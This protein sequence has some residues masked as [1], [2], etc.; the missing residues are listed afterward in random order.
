MQLSNEVFIT[1]PRWDNYNNSNLLSYKFLSLWNSTNIS[2]NLNN[3]FQCWL[4]MSITWRSF[5]YADARATLVYVP[6][7][8]AFLIT[9]KDC[10]Q[11]QCNP[12]INQTINRFA[13]I[14][15]SAT[16]SMQYINFLYMCLVFQNT[17]ILK[18]MYYFC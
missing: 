17:P 3:G 18:N 9:Q 13:I 6:L 10:I 1:R 14:L 2:N 16:L 8:D 12:P 5:K 4:H 7:I 11:K 15:N